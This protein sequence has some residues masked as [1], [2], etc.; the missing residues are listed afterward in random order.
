MVGY[1]VLFG[2]YFYLLHILNDEDVQWVIYT[3]LFIR[4][5]LI[6]SIPNLS[7]DIYRYLWDG[8]IQAMG[9]NPYTLAPK[10]VM[11][12]G[13]NHFKDAG[14]LFHQIH[15]IRDLSA[16]APLSEAIFYVSIKT[17]IGHQHLA[18]I[19]IKF[20][21]FIAE[22]FSISALLN[23]LKHFK[24]PAK[25]IFIYALSPLA[26]IEIAGNAHTEAFVICML[27][28]ALQYY[29]NNKPNRAIFFYA[30]SIA[31]GLLPL[32]FLPIFLVRNSLKQNIK[33]I[34][35]LAVYLF[36]VFGLY[37]QNR[38]IL[39]TYSVS[40]QQYYNQFEFNSMFYFWLNK[41]VPNSSSL[42]VLAIISRVCTALSFSLLVFLGYKNRKKDIQVLL[43][44]VQ[45]FLSLF[46]ILFPVVNPWYL[47]PIIMLTVFV[48][49][50]SILL[51][52]A[53][54]VASALALRTSTNEN[55]HAL[56]S[57]FYLLII[58]IWI[59]KDRKTTIEISTKNL[60]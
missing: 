18:I 48:P 2:I 55:I 27:L 57:S 5:I 59:I 45:V 20:T 39:H 22:V 37:F 6:G 43:P 49:K 23:L 4:L 1:G 29:V 36:L 11:D 31:A 13:L 17:S 51:W 44:I 28:I 14:N 52:S 26:I 50:Q 10:D 58:V 53:L 46:F 60:N 3:S 21:L 7:N 16:F 33:F 32:F 19:F 35:F 24:L 47:L 12:G 8:N 30:L 41:I 40:L 42:L 25:N 56:A 34:I 38:E 9:F 54:C 15:S